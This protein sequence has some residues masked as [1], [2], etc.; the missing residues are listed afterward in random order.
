MRNFFYGIWQHHV[1][2]SLNDVISALSFPTGNMLDLDVMSQFCRIC[3]H[4]ENKPSGILPMHYK[5]ACANHG[6]SA[7]SMEVVGTYRTFE[8]SAKLS[9]FA[10]GV[11]I[12]EFQLRNSLRRIKCWPASKY[13]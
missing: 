1:I 11:N 2:S 10:F 13:F 7:S 4:H 3:N 8:R 6:G 12:R 9:K 5:N